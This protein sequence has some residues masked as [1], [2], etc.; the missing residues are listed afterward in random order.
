M[1]AVTKVTSPEGTVRQE[2]QTAIVEDKGEEFTN[3]AGCANF[4]FLF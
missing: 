4:C 2:Q 1:S 3:E